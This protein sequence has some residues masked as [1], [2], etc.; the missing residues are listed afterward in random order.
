MIK[1]VSV[2][3]GTPLRSVKIERNGIQ[4]G[5]LMKSREHLGD[6]NRA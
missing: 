6:G 3:K 5:H 4:V 1:I 2:E